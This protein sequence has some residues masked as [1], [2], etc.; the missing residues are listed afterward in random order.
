MPS[1]FDALLNSFAKSKGLALG[2]EPVGVEFSTERQSLAVTAHPVAGDLLVVE[3][4]I[5]DP[6]IRAAEMPQSIWLVLLQIN[7][8]ARMEHD[9]TISVD[10]EGIIRLGCLRHIAE[11]DLST[12]EA[13]MGEGLER[14][15]SLTDLILSLIDSNPGSPA[16]PPEGTFLRA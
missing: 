10:A 2:Q 1:Q 11:T 6:A 15:E 7:D 4:A 12:L 9:W 8:A 5:T 14:A 3:V 13:L 16:G